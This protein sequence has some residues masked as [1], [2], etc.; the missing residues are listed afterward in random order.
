M[1]GRR[2]VQFLR[3][4]E[5]GELVVPREL[6]AAVGLDA[7]M[8]VRVRSEGKQLVLDKDPGGDNP[9]DG[10]LGRKLPSDLFA[11]I[12]TEQE[13]R[14]RK[15]LEEWGGRVQQAAEDDTPPDH[16]FGRD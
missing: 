13:E 16:P 9:L 15:Q 12:A 8:R 6:L 5:R 11:K 4:N 3:V 14:R 1:S 10:E 7:K 2:D